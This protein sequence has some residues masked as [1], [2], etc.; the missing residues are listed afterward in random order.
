[1]K[2]PLETYKLLLR[3]YQRG[4]PQGLGHYPEGA[5]RSLQGLEAGELEK[6]DD[7]NAMHDVMY[8]IFPLELIFLR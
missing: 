6:A 3:D 2:E 1:M 7:S 5:I 4:Q 8:P